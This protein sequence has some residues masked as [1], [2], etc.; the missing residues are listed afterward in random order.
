M[1]APASLQRTL[2]ETRAISLYPRSLQGC[3]GVGG[4]G[5]VWACGFG[6]RGGVIGIFVVE[7]YL[8]YIYI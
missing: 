1:A 2:G 6:G 5:A 8:I 4:G 3:G 7:G